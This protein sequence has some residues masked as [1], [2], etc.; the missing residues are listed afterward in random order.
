ML[1][2][3]RRDVE[4]VG[5]LAEATIAH[6]TQHGFPYYLAWAGALLGWSRSALGARED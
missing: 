4:E 1:N 5:R 3:F 2:Q 6:S